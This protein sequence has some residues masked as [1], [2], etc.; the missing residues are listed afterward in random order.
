MPHSVIVNG[1]HIVE[2]D[3]LSSGKDRSH[4]ENEGLDFGGVETNVPL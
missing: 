2:G 4:E 3:V 1:N